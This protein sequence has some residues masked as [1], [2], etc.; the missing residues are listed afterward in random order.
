MEKTLKIA[1]TLLVSSSVTLV[2]SDN[3]RVYDIKSAKVEYSIKGS[4]EIMGSKISSDGSKILIFD[5]YGSKSFTHEK[6]VDSQTIMGKANITKINNIEIISNGVV[7]RADLNAKRI[8]RSESLMGLMGGS[9]NVKKTGEDMMKKLGGKITGTD[10]V[11]GY[12]CDVWEFMGTKQCIY[13][14]LPLR[15]ETNMMGISNI[16]VAIK[17]EFD[18]TLSNSDFELPNL[19]VYELDMSNTVNGLKKLD[20]SKLSQMDKQSKIDLKKGREEL[21]ELKI[22]MATAFK[23]AGIKDGEIPTEAQSI[24]LQESMMSAMLPKIKAK[25]LKEEKILRMGYNCIKDANTLE[26]ANVCNDK[27]N[28]LSNEQEEP[29]TEWNPQMKKKIL[30]FLE[31]FLNEI[32]PCIKKANSMQELKSC[33][34]EN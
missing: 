13:K 7:Y 20:K 4:G 23:S 3:I 6:K 25:A 11:L 14:G 16:E 9:L 31:N 10:K 17:A 30:G 8:I 34:P 2:A 12:T 32:S 29:F 28:A 19:P 26:E 5:N 15:V 18:I 27:A 33:S 22:A 1:L 24:S 21:S